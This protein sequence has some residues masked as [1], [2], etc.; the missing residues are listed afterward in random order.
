MANWEKLFPTPIW[1]ANFH[2]IKRTQKSV[3]KDQQCNGTTRE[4]SEQT[5]HTEGN[6]IGFKW[7]FIP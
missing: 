5:V 2:K 7:T 6:T 4:G 3:R 1:K